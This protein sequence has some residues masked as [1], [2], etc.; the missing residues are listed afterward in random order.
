[1]G[2]AILRGISEEPYWDVPVHHLPGLGSRLHADELH[3]LYYAA[4]EPVVSFFPRTSPLYARAG[5]EAERV[6]GV[7]PPRPV[8][9]VVVVLFILR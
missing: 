1:M 7:P 5:L 2:V 3:H 4:S 8:G 6:D 9:L